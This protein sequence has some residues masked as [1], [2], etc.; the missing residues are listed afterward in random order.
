[1]DYSPEVLA[2]SDASM[3]ALD[4]PEGEKVLQA[5]LDG[6]MPIPYGIA[7]LLVISGDYEYRDML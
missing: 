4:T 7:R 6:T 5:M 3:K 1:M 2:M